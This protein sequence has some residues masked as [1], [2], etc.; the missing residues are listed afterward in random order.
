MIEKFVIYFL[1]KPRVRAALAEII[2]RELHSPAN[3]IDIGEMIKH[4]C[5][6]YFAIHRHISSSNLSSAEPF[7][8]QPDHKSSA[9]SGQMTSNT[10]AHLDTLKPVC[11]GSPAYPAVRRHSRRSR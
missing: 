8:P 9:S 2:E 11:L 7:E 6:K 10:S 5:E 1:K 4:S 3:K